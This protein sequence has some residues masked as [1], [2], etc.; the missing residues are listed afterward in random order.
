MRYTPDVIRRQLEQPVLDIKTGDTVD[1]ILD[2]PGPGTRDSLIQ[3]GRILEVTVRRVGQST[4]DAGI[5]VDDCFIEDWSF[6]APD[7]EIEDSRPDEPFVLIDLPRENVLHVHS[8]M[9][10]NFQKGDLVRVRLS[11]PG[12]QHHPDLRGDVGEYYATVKSVWQHV[13]PGV[14]VIPQ[15]WD[16]VC[17]M[18]QRAGGK[19]WTE[20]NNFRQH[21]C[22]YSVDV[23]DVTL[24]QREM[25]VLAHV[26]VKLPCTSIDIDVDVKELLE[27]QPG[28]EVIMCEVLD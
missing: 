17:N 4:F 22:I 18:L 12:V 1:V 25:T 9:T 5:I 6:L 19:S 24:V 3:Y 23:R 7:D 27:T 8:K 21:G 28:I 15:D 26:H 10:P 16:K 20:I 11:S 13:A 14:D 2:G